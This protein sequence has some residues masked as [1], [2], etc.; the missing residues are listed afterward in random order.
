ML[1][2]NDTPKPRGHKARLV[3]LFAL[4]A[5]LAAGA[6]MVL[7]LLHPWAPMPGDASDPTKVAQAAARGVSASGGSYKSYELGGFEARVTDE[8][9]ARRVVEALGSSLGMSDASSQLTDPVTNAVGDTSYYRFA[10]RSAGVPVLGRSVTV[11]ATNGTVDNIAGNATDVREKDAKPT[12]SQ[13]EAAAAINDYA[14]KELGATGAADVDELGDDDLVWWTFDVDEPMLAWRTTATIPGVGP[15]EVVVGARDAKVLSCVYG[16]DEVTLP[17]VDGNVSIDVDGYS[18]DGKKIKLVST[19]YRDSDHEVK[20]AVKTTK[21]GSNKVQDWYPTDES[22][23]RSVMAGEKSRASKQGVSAIAAMNKATA[24][25]R[26]VLGRSS[27]D[28][29]GAPLTVYTDIYNYPG[30]MIES[31]ANAAWNGGC[32]CFYITRAGTGKNGENVFAGMTDVMGHEFTH[33]VISSEVDGSLSGVEGTALGE[34]ISDVMGM[35]ARRHDESTST[36]PSWVMGGVDRDAK[37][38]RKQ[39][40]WFDRANNVQHYQYATYDELKE[41]IDANEDGVDCHDGATVVSHTA[42]LIW[43]KWSAGGDATD[44]RYTDQIAELFYRSIL[45]MARDSDFEQW[46]QSL[47]N[48]AASME[49]DGSITAGQKSVVDEVLNQQGISAYGASACYVVRGD[50]DLTVHTVTGRPYGLYRVSFEATDGSVEAPE[51]VEVRVGSAGPAGLIPLTLKGS[52]FRSGVVYDMKIEDLSGTGHHVPVHKT[53]VFLP[54]V[55]DLPDSQPGEVFS[56]I[57]GFNARVDVYTPFGEPV[58]YE[59]P[60]KVDSDAKVVLALDTSGSM[61]GDPYRAVSNAVEKFAG[62]AQ[63]NKL[64]VGVVTFSDEAIEQLTPDSYDYVRLCGILPSQKAVGS[65]NIEDAL[66]KSA[67]MLEGA[68]GSKAIVLM[69]DGMPNCGKQDAELVEYANELKREGITLYTVGF[70]NDLTGSELSSAQGLMERLASDDYHFEATSGNVEEFFAQIAE[71]LSGTRYTL[72]R[73]A[74][75]VDVTVVSDGEVLSSASD[76]TLTSSFGSVTLTSVGDG[77]TSESSQADG[78]DESDTSDKVKIV[79]I[80]QGSDFEVYVNGTGKGTMDYSISYMGADGKFTDERSFSGVPVSKGALIQS[81][82]AQTDST[83][84]DIDSDGDGVVDER[85]RTTATGSVT[86]VAPSDV[87]AHRMTALVVGVGTL[88][89]L[90]GVV[91]YRLRR[92]RA[93]A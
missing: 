82:T 87:A 77:S 46:G 65:T 90:V 17:G 19:L 63:V 29:Q 38:A 79:R 58:N 75:P 12:V 32:G 60:K 48:A 59:Q 9:D 45:N 24:F 18:G 91:E 27:Y 7:A 41:A 40:S 55:L 34:G 85:W 93:C 11:S 86:K 6:G 14:K 66:K 71:Q 37:I 88:T 64:P 23:T 80:K 8:D 47:R 69:S 28:G 51:P 4:L 70:F 20:A 44:L 31:S 16:I 33:A 1:D 30:Q 22:T 74:C 61:E 42:Y 5:M 62:V 83:T 56:D 92:R 15:Y 2:N 52:D 57:E 49:K 26:N 89:L 25:Y 39:K 13:E 35:C 10:E 67:K 3:A 81:S 84:L 68:K 72:I 78:G 36:V 53:I 73:V 50:A 76:Q 43:Q 21:A 54:N